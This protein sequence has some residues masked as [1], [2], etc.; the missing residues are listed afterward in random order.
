MKLNAIHETWNKS[1]VAV[2]GRLRKA[3]KD[4]GGSVWFNPDTGKAVVST[5]DP[6]LTEIVKRIVGEANVQGGHK[7]GSKGWVEI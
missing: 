4:R 7:P 1:R 5:G 6:H 3:L 2:L